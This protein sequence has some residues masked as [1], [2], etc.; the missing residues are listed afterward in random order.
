MGRCLN[1][2][3]HQTPG[4]IKKT[5]SHFVK[6]GG[7][8]L[9]FR[10]YL[11]KYSYKWRGRKISDLAYYAHGCAQNRTFTDRYDNEHLRGPVGMHI[12]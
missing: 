4:S 8:G 10:S 5:K 11:Y 2:S 3:N 12:C 1:G 9:E 7:G 6:F